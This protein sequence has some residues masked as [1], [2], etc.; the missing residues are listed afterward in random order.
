MQICPVVS[1][2]KLECSTFDIDHIEAGSLR[3]LRDLDAAHQTNRHR[4]DDLV[5]RQFFL[6][7]VAHNFIRPH[8]FSSPK[9]FFDAMLARRPF[10][11]SHIFLRIGK[12]DREHHIA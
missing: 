5:P 7:D 3:D 4:S 10:S 9:V 1:S 6:D 2:E 12:L 8:G 11:S